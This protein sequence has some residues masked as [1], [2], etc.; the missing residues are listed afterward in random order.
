V[1]FY[2]V[3]EATKR[4]RQRR[5]SKLK[6]LQFIRKALNAISVTNA[7][8]ETMDATTAAADDDDDDDLSYI[9]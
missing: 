8:L 5:R 2:C 6:Q 7:M 1:I 9:I 4:Y 3:I